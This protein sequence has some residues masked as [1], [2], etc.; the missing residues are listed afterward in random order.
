MESI[1]KRIDDSG[2]HPARFPMH[3]CG[4]ASRSAG[5]NA[6][7]AARQARPG[8][9]LS[10]ILTQDS[11]QIYPIAVS[12]RKCV[13]QNKKAPS[14]AT[15]GG[16]NAMRCSFPIVFQTVEH[17]GVRIEDEHADIGLASQVQNIHQ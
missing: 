16:F 5:G 4:G 15:R 3:R 12:T 2:Q 13:T 14:L 17:R 10:S 11:V 9:D 7:A 8:G 1:R 6:A